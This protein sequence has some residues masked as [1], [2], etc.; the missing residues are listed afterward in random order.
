VPV[1][2]AYGHFSHVPTAEDL[3]LEEGTSE[4]TKGALGLT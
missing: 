2:N 1:V 4:E 3:A